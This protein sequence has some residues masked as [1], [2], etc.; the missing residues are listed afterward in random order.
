MTDF[1]H[2]NDSAEA[3]NEARKVR[4]GSCN[5]VVVVKNDT[6]DTL[7]ATFLG[8][9]L[10]KRLTVPIEA[11]QVESFV[12][13]LFDDEKRAKFC[14][15]KGISEQMANEAVRDGAVQ[16]FEDFISTYA[17]DYKPK[18][19]TRS[20]GKS[21]DKNDAVVEKQKKP[22]KSQDDSKKRKHTAETVTSPEK[23]PKKAAPKKKSKKEENEEAVVDNKEKKDDAE[24]AGA[25]STKIDGE[26]EKN[27]E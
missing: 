22:K 7:T 6:D 3:I 13:T 17:P 23:K 16:S 8:A 11:A 14:V 2:E 20:N 26:D 1:L 18:P 9:T 10:F 12:D 5:F 25:D 21:V 15:K 27:K 4:S 19:R 24:V